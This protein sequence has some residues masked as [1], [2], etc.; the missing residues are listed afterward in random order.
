MAAHFKHIIKVCDD[1]RVEAQRLVKVRR[2]L[3]SRKERHAKQG[4]VGAGR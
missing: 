2:A 1:G 4:E 3:P